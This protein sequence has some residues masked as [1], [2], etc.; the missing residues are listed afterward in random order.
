MFRSINAI[1]SGELIGRSFALV[2]DAAIV[3]RPCDAPQAADV[4][5]AAQ[6]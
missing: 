3:A 5:R 6:A 4:A 2:G 1:R